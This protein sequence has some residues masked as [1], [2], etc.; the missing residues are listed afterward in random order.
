MEVEFNILQILAF[1]ELHIVLLRDFY[2][3]IFVNQ[4]NSMSASDISI[5]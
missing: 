3:V 2:I 1:I 5:F 4:D